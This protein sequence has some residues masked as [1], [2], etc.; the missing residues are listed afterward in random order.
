VVKSTNRKHI[1]HLNRAAEEI[2]VQYQLY[3]L[4]TH[5]HSTP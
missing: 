5:I 1:K 2:G 4:L 3:I